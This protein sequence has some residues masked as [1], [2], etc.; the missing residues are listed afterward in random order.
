[1]LLQ[2]LFSDMSMLLFC[3]PESQLRPDA[4]HDY[5]NSNRSRLPRS[6]K[7]AIFIKETNMSTG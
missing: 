4:A 3:L 6:G 7:L 2:S 5:V 1:M